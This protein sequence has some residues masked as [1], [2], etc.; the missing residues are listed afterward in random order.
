MSCPAYQRHL[1][2]L[3]RF[4][5]M[6]FGFIIFRCTYGSDDDW[7]RF[8]EYLDANVR[9]SLVEEEMGEALSRIDWSAQEDRDL[10]DTSVN[11]VREYVFCPVY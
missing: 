2:A 6:K 10:D 7:A 8:F 3:Q 11:V 5:D 1:R 9:A 4:P